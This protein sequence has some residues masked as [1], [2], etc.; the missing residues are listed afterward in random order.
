[1]PKFL[2]TPFCFFVISIDWKLKLKAVQNH[3][4][5]ILTKCTILFT[6]LSKISAY[7]LHYIFS[8]LFNYKHTSS[9]L[10]IREHCLQSCF[11]VF[12]LKPW[13]Q[14][15]DPTVQI[16]WSGLITMHYRCG[17]GI[18]WQNADLGDQQHFVRASLMSERHS[19]SRMHQINFAK[20]NS[21]AFA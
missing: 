20:Q 14:N 7:Y 3:F 10:K 21:P 5:K 6:K 4:T 17:K 11:Q 13:I 2:M 15:I 12:L 8:F 19:F 1:M 18:P 16:P 9:T